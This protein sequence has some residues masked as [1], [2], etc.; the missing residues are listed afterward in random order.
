M[1]VPKLLLGT[2]PNAVSDHNLL[3][4]NRLSFDPIKKKVLNR[5]S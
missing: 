2:F 3:S 1:G 4:T 5:A